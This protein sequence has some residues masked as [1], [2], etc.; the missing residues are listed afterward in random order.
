MN[1]APE[2]YPG[3]K[4]NWDYDPRTE[5]GKPLVDHLRNNKLWNEIRRASNTNPLLKEALDRAIMIYHLS[6]KDGKK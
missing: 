1:Q 4:E 3:D 2:K 6:K 5:D